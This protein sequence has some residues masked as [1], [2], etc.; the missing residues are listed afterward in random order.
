[1]FQN[2]FIIPQICFKFDSINVRMV[3]I[4]LHVCSYNEKKIGVK[5]GN[6]RNETGQQPE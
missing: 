5:P 4:M 1:M 3:S 2:G 6:S